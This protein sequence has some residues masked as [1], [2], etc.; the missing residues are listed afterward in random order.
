MSVES[1]KYPFPSLLI[2]F[3]ALNVSQ[4][5]HIKLL[6]SLITPAK[7]LGGHILANFHWN[8]GDLL[9]IYIKHG[10]WSYQQLG[11]KKCRNIN[12]H[13]NIHENIMTFPLAPMGVLAPRS[14]QVSEN[15]WNFH[16]FFLNLKTPPQGARRGLRIFWG[17]NISFF[18]RI[19]P[20]WSFRTLTK[21]PK[22]RPQGARGWGFEFI[23]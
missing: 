22:N 6:W 13:I 23:F 3:P 10:N 15:F 8:L 21:K 12:T 18:V 20:L 14:V 2:C 16:F 11:F 5:Y 9:I 17:V 7:T 4:L 1:W 19:N